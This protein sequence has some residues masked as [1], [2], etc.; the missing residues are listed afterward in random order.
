M[1]KKYK[2]IKIKTIHDVN[3]GDII[4][5]KNND[6]GIVID[7]GTTFLHDHN[8]V[9][10]SN[11]DSDDNES[12]ISKYYAEEFLTGEIILRKCVKATQ[13]ATGRKGK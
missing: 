11:F 7:K 1:N 13:S 6:M 4:F 8:F 5:F 10:V 12:K 9:S 3:K 2:E